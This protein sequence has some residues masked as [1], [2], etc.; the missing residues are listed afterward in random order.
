MPGC[1]GW[2]APAHAAELLSAY[3][4]PV[5]PT[6][7]A[8]DARDVVK[9]AGTQ[10]GYP[11]ALKTADPSLVHKTDVGAVQLGLANADQ[12]G[13]AAEEIAAAAGADAGFVVQPMAEPGVEMIAG[14]TQ[15]PAF[16]PLV[17]VGAG[18]V[19]AELLGDRTFRITPLT[20]HDAAEA[21]RSLRLSP[22]LFGYRG[23]PRAAVDQLEDLL[24]R[25]GRLA[26]DHPEITELDCNPVIVTPTT[27]V[28][29]DAKIRITPAPGASQ[30]LLRRLS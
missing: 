10:L 20:D 23:R 6:L 17:M 27:A 3:G 25:L 9:I 28:V 29:V 18:G 13:Q 1:D 16:G 2:L 12:V 11:V 15:D 26:D 4:I 19:T 24:L 30:Q 22:L 7:F 8:A 5:V 14:I 21:V